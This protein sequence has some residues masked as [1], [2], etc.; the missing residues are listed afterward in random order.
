LPDESFDSIALSF[1]LH[2]LPGSETGPGKWRAFDHLK[3]KLKPSGVLFGSTILG[4][5]EPPLLRQRLLMGVYNRKGIF[6]NARDD[7][8][9]LERELRGR[10]RHVEISTRGVVAL[11]SARP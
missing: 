7:R 9:T 2:C 3:S 8:A 5:P 4:A 10:F 1:L 11:F 6:G